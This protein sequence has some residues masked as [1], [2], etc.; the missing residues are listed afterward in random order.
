[1]HTIGQPSALCKFNSLQYLQ[2]TNRYSFHGLQKSMN[3]HL[4]WSLFSL[5]LL[6]RIHQKHAV[7]SQSKN[8]IGVSIH[9][10]LMLKKLIHLRGLYVARTCTSVFSINMFYG[11]IHL[12]SCMLV[13]DVRVFHKYAWVY[14]QWSRHLCIRGGAKLTEIES[15]TGNMQVNW[16]SNRTNQGLSG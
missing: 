16:K 4:L 8:C 10:S 11:V 13:W 12:S 3:I 7:Q 1:M 14:R 6:W 15:C 5:T 2:Q 9:T